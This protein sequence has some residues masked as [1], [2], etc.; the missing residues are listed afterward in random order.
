M[1][2]GST[3]RGSSCPPNLLEAELCAALIRELTFTV[4]QLLGRIEW[5]FPDRALTH[6]IERVLAVGHLRGP[7]LWR[8]F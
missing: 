7:D 8:L 4:P 1:S 5:I 2:P 3:E 6:E